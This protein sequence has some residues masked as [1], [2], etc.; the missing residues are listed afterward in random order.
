MATINTNFDSGVQKY[1][2]T[3]SDGDVIASFKLNPTDIK[4]AKRCEEV[5]EQLEKMSETAPQFATV[6]D[7]AKY[8]DDLESK[9][10]YMLGYDARAS[11]F[12]LLS[13]TTILPNGTLFAQKVVETI[14]QSIEP[15]IKKRTEK[16][17]AAVAKHT[18]KYNK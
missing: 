15:E 2:F 14:V 6:E 13:A 4:L 3:D 18:A 7:A 9:V 1:T 16:M 17:Q 12:G 8:N 11:L 10:C 5:A